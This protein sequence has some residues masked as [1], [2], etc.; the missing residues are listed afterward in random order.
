MDFRKL[1]VDFGMWEMDFAKF[2]VDYFSAEP[3]KSA[4]KVE[5]DLGSGS[6]K[7]FFGFSLF[8]ST[9]LKIKVMQLHGLSL[10]IL[11]RSRQSH[12]S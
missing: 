10:L 11:N 5:N 1:E 8:F 3:S 4:E 6:T 2:K 7:I 9:T 12:Q